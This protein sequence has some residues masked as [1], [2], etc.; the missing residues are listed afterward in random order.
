MDYFDIEIS[1][2]SEN[3]ISP[4]FINELIKMEF[5]SYSSSEVFLWTIYKISSTFVQF[6]CCVNKELLNITNLKYNLNFIF[7]NYC[8][9]VIVEVNSININLFLSKLLI[10]NYYN[11]NGTHSRKDLS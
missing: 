5:K 4:Y 7:S 10:S 1:F 3:N 2:N 6:T 11:M 9:N 8:C